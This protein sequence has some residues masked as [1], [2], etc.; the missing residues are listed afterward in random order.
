MII[1][2]E[3]RCVGCGFCQISC[4]REA[5]RVWAYARIDHDLCSDCFGGIHRFETNA[6][7]E[8]RDVTLNTDQTL[9]QCACVLNC[10]AEALSR[11]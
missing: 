5:F 6:R 3:E 2:D 4:P 8:D 1:I 9:W 7:L 10:P 11:Q